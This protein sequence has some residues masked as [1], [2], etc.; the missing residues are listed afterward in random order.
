MTTELKIELET[1]LNEQEIVLDKREVDELLDKMTLHIG[2][3]DSYLRDQLIYKAFGKLI[4]HDYLTGPKINDLLSTCLDDKH[5]FFQIDEGKSDAVLTRSFSALVIALL[6]YK[7]KDIRTLPNELVQLA[8]LGSIDY[9]YKEQDY[10]GYIEGKGWAHSIAHGSDLLAQAILH[11]IFEKKL[12]PDCLRVIQGCLHVEYAYIDEEEERLLA[13]IDA[14]M[15]QG[16]S[17]ETLWTWL[18]QLEL[19]NLEPHSQYRV[20]WNIKLFMKALYFA[21]EEQSDFTHVQ[22]WIKK[23]ILNKVV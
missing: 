6:L 5:L 12:I 16:M 13:V 4:L 17:S 19:L 15:K 14:L 21:L 20:E 7:D 3:P 11:P 10:R 2:H 8:I 9:L 22:T 18:K 1:V 23:Q